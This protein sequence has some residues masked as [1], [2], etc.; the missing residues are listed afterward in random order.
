M[1]RTVMV[2][3]VRCELMR[4]GPLWLLDFQAASRI[5]LKPGAKPEVPFAEGVKFDVKQRLCFHKCGSALE[6]VCFNAM[7]VAL[8]SS[9]RTRQW[10]GPWTEVCVIAPRTRVATCTPSLQEVSPSTQSTQM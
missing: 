9:P 4:C 6:A 2:G 5:C 1:S 10:P 7:A 8:R 3:G